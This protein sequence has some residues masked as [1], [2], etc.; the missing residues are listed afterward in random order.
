MSET[1]TALI[2]VRLLHTVIWAILA[3][4]IV[5]LPFLAVAGNF[6]WALLITALVLVE[7]AV[8]ALNHG[9]CPLTNV[10]ARYTT[11]RTDNFDIYLPRWIARRNKLIFGTLFV[12]GE[13]V[14]LWRW[15]A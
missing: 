6:K 2:A 3:G 11:D 5:A 1:R 4:C 7:C 13:A 9:S 14:A 8:L 15:L 12:V 10:A